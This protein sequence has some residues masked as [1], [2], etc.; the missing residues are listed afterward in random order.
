MTQCGDRRPGGPAGSRRRWCDGSA[1]RSWGVVCGGSAAGVW[2]VATFCKAGQMLSHSSEQPAASALG[3]APLANGPLDATQ[4]RRFAPMFKALGDPVRLRL[5]SMIASAGGGEVCVCDLTGA[6]HL[7]GPTISHHLKVLREAGLVD[8]DRRGTW[9]YYRLIP[10]GLTACWPP[11]SRRRH[12]RSADRRRRPGGTPGATGTAAGSGPGRAGAGR[13]AVSGVRR[14]SAAGPAGRPRRW[15]CRG[16]GGRAAGSTAPTPGRCRPATR[17]RSGRAPRNRPRPARGSGRP[18]CGAARRRRGGPA[19]RYST[20]GVRSK[21]EFWIVRP[22]SSG[23]S[24]NIQ[25]IG[26]VTEKTHLPPGRST[27]A[28]SRIAA[29]ES[30]T[31]GIAPKAVHTMSNTLS[32]NGRASASACTSGTRTPVRCAP[33]RACRSM[34]AERSM[35]ATSAPSPA[36]HRAAAAAPAPSSSTRRPRTSP[37]SRASASRTPSGHHTKSRSP[38]KEPCSAWYSSASRSH[39]ARFA[40]RLSASLTARRRTGVPG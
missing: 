20:Y 19:R 32:A 31:N 40:T 22:L 38:R 24:Q 9:V 2:T 15:P 30:A 26:W 14:C 5:L 12:V 39:H 34:P 7:T 10:A 27:R 8:S 1:M 23:S 11:C 28:T 35:A 13:A 21:Y 25:R 29:A 37:S 18:A 4:A 33:A 16:R 6:F 36:S 17:A 3:G